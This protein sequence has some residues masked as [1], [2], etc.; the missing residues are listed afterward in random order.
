MIA[1]STPYRLISKTAIIL[2]VSSAFIACGQLP[3]TSSVSESRV[4]D[5]STQS[6]NIAKVVNAGLPTATT[7]YNCQEFTPNQTVSISGHSKLADGCDLQNKGVQFVLDSSNSSLDCHGATLSPA[8]ATDGQNHKSGSAIT[9]QP[10]TD[11]AISN[12]SVANCHVQ[13]YDHALHIRQ[14]TSPNQRYSKG[15]TDPNANRAL[16]PHD[17]DIINLSS[18]GSTNS[19]IFVGDHIHHVNFQHLHIQGSGTVGLY[20]EFGSQH[21]IISDSVFVD[22]GFRTFKPNREA[23][24]VDSSAFNTI[25][26][27]QFI[28][29][30]A[31]GIFLYRN[32]FEHADDNSRYN[33]FK[34]T[35]SAQDNLIENNTFANEPVGVWVASRQSRNLKGFECGAY[36]IKDSLF[37]SYHLDSAKDNQIIGNHF[38]DVAEAI[39]VE[40]DGTK[41]MD[42]EFGENVRQAIKVGSEI[43]EQSQAGA[44]SNTLIKGNHFAPDIPDSSRIQIRPASRATTS[45]Q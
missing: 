38:Y 30:G 32:C 4:D 41:I 8:P 13:G 29:N 15:L 43:R 11:Q 23:I 7:I 33:H 31:G 36:L 28:H 3:V 2:A 42:N 18:V 12:I 19:G 6:K 20:L 39:I 14:K 5:S 40:D 16:A 1:F 25:K 44:V 9:I 34:R 37:A 10:K 26:N 45:I 35:E 21:N 27:N 17:I 22:N 24:A